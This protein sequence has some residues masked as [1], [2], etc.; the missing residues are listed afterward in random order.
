[1]F[2]DHRTGVGESVS[3]SFGQRQNK[4]TRAD[5]SSATFGHGRQRQLKPRRRPPHFRQPVAECFIPDQ[6]G[7]RSTVLSSR[8]AEATQ[9]E[10]TAGTRATPTLS[11]S[12]LSILLLIVT[13]HSVAK[14][15]NFMRVSSCGAT[16]SSSHCILNNSTA[17]ATQT[18]TRGQVLG[19]LRP[20][21]T[22]KIQTTQTPARLQTARR[23]VFHP[24]SAEGEVYTVVSSR[25]AE[26]T[27]AEATAGT[28]ATP[29]FSPSGL[30]I[31]LFIVT[32]HSV[33]KRSNF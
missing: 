28:R 26:A 2:S 9:S 20:W 16:S 5:K 32:E 19:H 12:G 29:T 4:R 3:E 15:S 17:K 18:H 14:R 25:A 30:S 21:P 27:Q 13:E 33:A 31:L 8:A 22:E 6:R 23:R 1:M 24:R 7:R 11:P 10:A